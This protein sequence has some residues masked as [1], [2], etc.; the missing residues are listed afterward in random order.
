M[1]LWVLG[2][3]FNHLSDV[4]EECGDKGLG[5]HHR[6]TECTCGHEESGGGHNGHR[7]PGISDTN[8]L[9]NQEVI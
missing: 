3:R 4:E 6:A 9:D 2:S 7:R 8:K 5:E 1:C